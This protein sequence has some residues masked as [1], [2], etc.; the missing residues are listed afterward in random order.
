MQARPSTHETL[1]NEHGISTHFGGAANSED[2]DTE[3]DEEEMD[4]MLGYYD[5]HGLPK[6]SIDS[7]LALHHMAGVLKNSRT[8]ASKLPKASTSDQKSVRF[9]ADISHDELNST[10]SE[11]EADDESNDASSSCTSSASEESDS[12]DDSEASSSGSENENAKSSGDSSSDDDSAPEEESSKNI[13]EEPKASGESENMTLM[14]TSQE[15]IPPGGGRKQTKARNTRRRNAKMLLRMQEKGILPDD[16]T[17]AEFSRLRVNA[18]TTKEEA[19]AALDAIRSTQTSETDLDF[20]ARRQKLL[21]SLE[22]G[23]IEV[24]GESPEANQDSIPEASAQSALPT[25]VE[26]TESTD[27]SPRRARLD[28]GAGR[29]LLFGA[30]GLKTPKTKRDE[31]KLRSNLM[32]DVRPLVSPKPDSLE[33][34]AN[35]DDADEDPEAWRESIIYRAVECCHDDVQLSE[36]PFPFVQRWD[37]QQQGGGSKHSGQSGKRKKDLRDDAQFKDSTQRPSK[38]QKLRKAR[39]GY[40][41]EQEYLD[42]SYE[43]SYEEDSWAVDDGDAAREAELLDENDENGARSQSHNSSNYAEDAGDSQEPAD[44]APLPEDPSSLPDLMADQVTTGMTIAFKQLVMS[45]ETKWQP[46]ISAYRTAIVIASPGNG[47]LHLTLALRDRKRPELNYDEETGDRIFGR[48]DM[49][50]EEDDEEVEDDGML[51][52]Q[53]SELLEPKIVQDAPDSLITGTDIGDAALT[54][55]ANSES[56]SAS[57]KKDS[58]EEQF[59]HITETPLHSEVP[60]SHSPPW[61]IDLQEQN[62]IDQPNATKPS[63][64]EYQSPAHKDKVQVAEQERPVTLIDST[65]KATEAEVISDEARDEISL[66]IKEAGFRSSV[67]SSIQKNIRPDHLE[68]PGDTAVFEKLMNDMTE[69]E[70]HFPSSPK[71][72]GF[73]SSSPMRQAGA[74]TNSAADVPDQPLTSPAPQSSWQTIP[75]DERSS[76]PAETQ[77]GDSLNEPLDTPEESWETINPSTLPT[78]PAK[79]KSKRKLHKASSIQKANLVWEQLSRQTGQNANDQSPIDNVQAPPERSIGAESDAVSERTSNG[80]IIYPKLSI[81]SS[82]TTQISDHGRQPDALFEDTYNTVLTGDDGQQPDALFKDTYNTILGGDLARPAGDSSTTHDNNM[83]QT[84]GLAFDAEMDLSS[85]ST[86]HVQPTNENEIESPGLSSDDPFPPLEVI[87][88]QRSATPKE[89]TPRT[90]RNEH[91]D[92][93]GDGHEPSAVASLGKSNYS[94]PKASG[95]TRTPKRSASQPNPKT[96]SSV[97]RSSQT[98]ASQ[99]QRKSFVIPEGSQVMDLTLSSDVEVDR[100]ALD[101]YMPPFR[102]YK[103]ADDDDDAYE[104]DASNSKKGGGWVKKKGSSQTDSPRGTGKRL[105]SSSQMSSNARSSRKKTVAKF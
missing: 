46:Q 79:R 18:S 71:F 12:V 87:M 49:P 23:G 44:L 105:R 41:E 93:D 80:N 62:P 64:T 15:S 8:R 88:S 74:R 96:R 26:K 92:G 11:A 36:P 91:E 42:G 6:G 104:D 90:S 100:D 86:K 45:E 9:A 7:G 101:A 54:G 57:K 59:S 60:E 52:L 27:P 70:N 94:T 55:S 1:P 82:F 10:P 97:P 66:L 72:N 4:P 34:T 99:S 17:A 81:D 32:K 102:R 16:T 65:E 22:S 48:F 53:F 77:T 19:M 75:F 69:V 5:H 20:A 3:N 37:P 30:L 95:N 40:T 31:E 2:S 98:P 28:L 38:K 67:P 13:P 103:L 33:P 51:N 73:G 47:E 24:G 39:H 56:P 50:V 84:D 68:S 14:G 29:R 78:Q 83:K 35:I 58:V 61:S 63:D 85:H 21:D 89:R 43:P 25:A 76:P